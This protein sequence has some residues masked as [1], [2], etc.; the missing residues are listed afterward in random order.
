MGEG[1]ADLVGA[2][3]LQPYLHQRQLAT[4]LQRLVGGDGGLAAGDRPGVDGYLFLL[5]VLHQKDLHPPFRRLRRT[6]RDAEIPLV[7]L[8]VADLL[9]DDPQRLG[10]LGGDDDAAGVAVDAVAQG[11]GKGVL[12]LGVPFPLLVE[13]RLNVVDESVDLL[14][15]V[16]VY[17]QPRPLVQQHQVLV[18]VHDGETGLEKRQEQIVLTGVVE[19]LVVDV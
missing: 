16:G 13:V 14:R 5:L 17:H 2:A 9:V 12:P 1:S 8:P 7:H 4:A 18:L 10:V 19:E 6:H 11:G 3:G 15:L